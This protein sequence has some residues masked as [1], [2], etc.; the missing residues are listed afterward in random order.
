MKM[1]NFGVLEGY[2]VAL[3]VVLT[4]A[5]A[6]SATIVDNL[7]GVISGAVYAV[8]REYDY[9]EQAVVTTIGAQ[10][11]TTPTGAALQLSSITLGI[12]ANPGSA[13][14]FKVDIYTGTTT[15]PGSLYYSLGSYAM[16]SIGGWCI[17]DFHRR[18]AGHL[19]GRHQLL[20]RSQ[21]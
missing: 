21:H 17:S 9:D 19:V 6:R 13:G 14:N 8:A 15:A 10:G 4:L 1:R 2:V 3:F 18:Y 12:R 16:E 11:F 5:S 20:G 7:D